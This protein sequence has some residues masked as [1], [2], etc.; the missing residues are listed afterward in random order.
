MPEHESGS[1]HQTQ[2]LINQIIDLIKTNQKIVDEVIHANTVLRSEISRVIPKM[3][4]LIGTLKDFVEMIAAAGRE[5]TTV[6]PEAMRPMT[7]Q[8]QKI[9]EQ[10][11]S[12]IE[13]LDSMN[14]K[15]R[16]GTPVSQ[17]LSSG[18]KIRREYNEV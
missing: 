12:I 2:S 3:D 17:V 18:M 10:N 9:V 4:E 8:L 15:L 6:G 13:A 11:Q 16:S 5:E 1:L 14:R 7:E